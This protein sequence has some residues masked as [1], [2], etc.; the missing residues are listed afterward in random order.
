MPSDY[1]TPVHFC[2]IRA[3][4]FRPSRPVCREVW[5]QSCHPVCTVASANQALLLQGHD[6]IYSLVGIS[7]T[8]DPSREQPLNTRRRGRWGKWPPCPPSVFSDLHGAL[9][10]RYTPGWLAP[11]ASGLCH[12]ICL[13]CWLSDHWDSW[14]EG[15]LSAQFC[16]TLCCTR[17]PKII[18][19]DFL[20][21]PGVNEKSPVRSH[22]T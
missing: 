11:V 19:T 20:V 14:G 10:R 18:L 4:F 1:P 21:T 8:T 9:P 13:C 17:H 3:S 7:L 2:A 15:D 16:K 6:H 5:Y 22:L 12:H